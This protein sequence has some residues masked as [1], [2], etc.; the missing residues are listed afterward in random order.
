MNDDI[1]KLHRS[2]YKKK[3]EK[4]DHPYLESSGDDD[5]FKG[6]V[7]NGDEFRRSPE[8]FLLNTFEEKIKRIVTRKEYL[9]S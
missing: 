1:K 9:I 4:D 6:P 2:A 5:R 3:T 7:L 8:C